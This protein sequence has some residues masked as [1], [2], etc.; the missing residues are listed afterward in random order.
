MKFKSTRQFVSYLFESTDS[1][2]NEE[3]WAD[4]FS[5]AIKPEQVDADAQTKGKTAADKFL[6]NFITNVINKSQGKV[7]LS[8]IRGLLKWYGHAYIVVRRDIKKNTK[9]KI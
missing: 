7:V 5:K 1:S 4:M 9:N 6:A 8:H 2:V 3:G